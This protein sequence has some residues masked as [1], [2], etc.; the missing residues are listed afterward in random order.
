MT[1]QYFDLSQLDWTVSG[2]LPEQWR[3]SYSFEIGA[4]SS[5]EVKAIPAKVPGSVQYALREAGII[6]DWNVG[7]NYRQCEWVENRHWIYETTLP[8]E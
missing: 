5:A 1:K 2:W 6:P 8:D 4:P 7:M 3:L